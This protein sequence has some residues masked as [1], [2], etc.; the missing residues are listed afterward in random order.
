MEQGSTDGTGVKRQLIVCLSRNGCSVVVPDIA[1]LREGG[2]SALEDRAVVV[3]VS[4]ESIIARGQ[5]EAR[6]AF[7]RKV[8]RTAPAIGPIAFDDKIGNG[9]EILRDLDGGVLIDACQELIIRDANRRARQ[10]L[11]GI[12]MSRAATLIGIGGE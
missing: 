1:G 7:M 6:P 12:V 5:C 2:L 3:R 4:T 9:S 10:D 8:E 11:N